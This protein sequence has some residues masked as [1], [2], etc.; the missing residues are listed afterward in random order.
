MAE[1]DFADINE[2][3][4]DELASENLWI[5]AYQGPYLEKLLVAIVRRI[6]SSQAS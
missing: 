2:D 6:N 4:H 1:S 5:L 3:A